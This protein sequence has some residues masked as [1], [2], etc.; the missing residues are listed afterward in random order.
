MQNTEQLTGTHLGSSGDVL[1][2]VSS[3]EC[4]LDGSRHR[5]QYHLTNGICGC[6]LSF[7]VH[8][9]VT[10]Y[11]SV[12]SLCF[13]CLAI[14]TNQHTGH[15]AERAVPCK[16]QSKASGSTAWRALGLSDMRVKDS[17]LTGLGKHQHVESSITLPL[18]RKWGPRFRPDSKDPERLNVFLGKK[19]PG[20]DCLY[21]IL[22]W[23]LQS[24]FGSVFL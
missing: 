7:L 9:V 8:A 12:G 11:S 15:H 2:R 17:I 13:H 16:W 24:Y 19:D 10:R 1:W 14:W 21:S 20:S 23:W 18:C 5:S 22:A 6:L 3:G 4:P